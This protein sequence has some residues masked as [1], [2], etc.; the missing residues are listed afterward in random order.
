[1]LYQVVL[2]DLLG[3]KIKDNILEIKPSIPPQW[4]GFKLIYTYGKTEYTILVD[5]KRKCEKKLSLDS[6]P[7]SENLVNLVD[8]GQKHIIRVF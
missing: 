3:I 2:E 6:R 8:D 1:V 5:N 7:I 4:T